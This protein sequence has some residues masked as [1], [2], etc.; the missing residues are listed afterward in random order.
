MPARS[1]E[2]DTPTT[3]SPRAAPV[4][5]MVVVAPA[6][7]HEVGGVVGG[8]AHEE[9]RP[10]GLEELA[11]DLLDALRQAGDA[12]GLVGDW[13]GM[14]DAPAE[15]L[16]ARALPRAHVIRPDPACRTRSRPTSPG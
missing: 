16:S 10:L 12:E 5:V 8:R 7:V 1:T 15:W 14:L 11:D 3:K 9:C 6:A 2:C 4:T 13:L